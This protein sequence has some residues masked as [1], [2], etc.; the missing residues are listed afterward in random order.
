MDTFDQ[1]VYS[2]VKQI[3][4]GSVITYGEIARLMGQPNNSRRVGY[5]MS[6]LPEGTDV[7]AHR[8]VNSAGRI[9]PHWPGQKELLL[10]EGISFRKNGCVDL[11]SA[12]WEGLRE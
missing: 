2:I 8:V 4:E 12:L 9:A 10:A 11:A 5:A 6:H 3:P 7:P 1:E